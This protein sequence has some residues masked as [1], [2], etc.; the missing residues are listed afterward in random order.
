MTAAGWADD[1]AVILLR[2]L[3]SQ[4]SGPA[5]W[6]DLAACRE[7]DPDAYFPDKGGSSRQAKAVCMRCEVRLQCLEWAMDNDEKFGI[8]GGLSDRQRR[9]RRVAGKE[10]AA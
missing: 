4:Q 6:M 3:M 7:T 2:V 9:A 10:R 8:W 5:H 1:G